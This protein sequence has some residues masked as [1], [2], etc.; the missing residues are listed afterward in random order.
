MQHQNTY[1]HNSMILIHSIKHFFLIFCYSKQKEQA[2][3]SSQK[4]LIHMIAF[5]IINK[6]GTSNNYVPEIFNSY[7]TV[8]HNKQKE[9]SNNFILEI[10]NLYDTFYYNK[11]KRNKQ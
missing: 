6:K 4:Y 11:P 5:T 3:I 8:D 10:F 9:T 1:I 7:D 2:I